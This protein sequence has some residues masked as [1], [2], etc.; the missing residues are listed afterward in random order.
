MRIATSLG[1]AGLAVVFGLLFVDSNPLL[2][3][4]TLSP[5]A[6]IV[7]IWLSVAAAR[8][9]ADP[10]DALARWALSVVHPAFIL[11]CGCAAAAA[12]DV[13]DTIA[14]AAWTAATGIVIFTL[15]SAHAT[16][17]RGT[18]AAPALRRVTVLG[19][20]VAASGPITR[21]LP[22]WTES[23]TPHAS[24]FGIDL[25]VADAA[26][27]L[28][29]ATT[30]VCAAHVT[31]RFPRGPWPWAVVLA[32]VWTWTLGW[33]HDTAFG[34]VV[35]AVVL[36]APVLL[37]P[38]FAPR[39]RAGEHPER[40]PV[41]AAATCLALACGGAIAVP[42]SLPP[43]EASPELVERTLRWAMVAGTA[44]LVRDLVV[45]ALLTRAAPHERWTGA[46]W[47]V[48]LAASWSVLGGLV[49][50]A[51]VPAA[52]AMFAG[53]PWEAMV[54]GALGLNDLPRAAGA[55]SAGALLVL[56]VLALVTRMG[57]DRRPNPA[58]DPDDSG[59]THGD[60]HSRA[61][62]PGRTIA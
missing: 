43:T 29:A 33:V 60:E 24:W 35:P 21:G 25:A 20:V 34:L 53:P 36:V 13:P 38:L 39:P 45:W 19:L 56:A 4:A 30:L 52:L 44:L 41:G 5:L 22:T 9:P 11:A 28:L 46:L 7:L 15:A 31:G 3:L 62:P 55:A 14:D 58:E 12:T 48:W 40:G 47:L 42:G 16:R 50:A 6:G 17:A 32:L 18:G 59:T 1:A 51:G 61:D 23:P 37:T 2:P 10:H 26:L 27:G 57:N 54:D 49:H 8:E